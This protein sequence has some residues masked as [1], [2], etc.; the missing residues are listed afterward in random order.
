[1]STLKVDAIGKFDTTANAITFDSNNNA[2]FTGS[3]DATNPMMNKNLLINGGMNVW[4]RDDSATVSTDAYHTADRW[5]DRVS[6]LGVFTVSRSTDVPSGQGFGYSM[7]W[8]CT[9]ADASP[10]AA[11]F[12][13]LEQRMEGQNLQHLLYGNSG[14]K[15]LTASFWV[16]GNKTGVYTCGLYSADNGGRHIMSSFTIS[17]SDTWEKKI[18][19]LDGDTVSALDNDE[20][21]SLKF[22]II[23]GAGSNFSSGT[24]ATTWAAYDQ[25]NVLADSSVNLAD[26]TSNE[27]Y[28]TGCQLEVGSQANNFEFEPFESIIRKCH[29][30]CRQWDRRGPTKNQVYTRAVYFGGVGQLADT[31]SVILT[32]TGTNM[33]DAPD[34]E[35][36]ATS[37]FT[38]SGTSGSETSSALAVYQDGTHGALGGQ[39][40][41]ID[42]TVSTGTDEVCGRVF[43][44]D[45]TNGYL[46]LNAEL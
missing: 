11:D 26:S 15:K 1:M 8:D 24:Q 18:I 10:A 21:E 25:A 20:E 13:I 5:K 30:Y 34:V 36:S 29:R 12:A 4:Q 17:A 28:I 2:S 6:G 9:T 43:I 7:K 37:D 38:F 22:W 14:A 46:R 41:T 39:D 32:F 16:K 35:Y 42:I 3:V 19:T 33:R 45:D 23:L 27:F 40:V 44:N 31:T